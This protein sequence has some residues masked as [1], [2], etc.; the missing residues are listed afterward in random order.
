MIVP[1]TNTALRSV[2]PASL[3]FGV[4]RCPLCAEEIQDE[5]IK[6]RFCGASLLPSGA[7]V[8]A[9]ARAPAEP[10]ISAMAI[11]SLVLGILWLYWIG[12]ILA[13]VLG[14]L[15]RAEINREAGKLAGRGL[16]RA[17]IVLGWIGV[18][19]LVTA[20]VSLALVALF[21]PDLLR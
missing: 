21:S 2:E 6:C 13:L 15:A 14:Y 16:A 8:P 12:S 1:Q 17:G 9:V 3:G 5:A 7:A 4:K 20:I 18:G 10:P 11:A 19:T